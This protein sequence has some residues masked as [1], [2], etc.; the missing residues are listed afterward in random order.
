[1]RAR[2]DIADAEEWADLGAWLEREYG[3]VDGLVNNAGIPF[4]SRLHEIE[5]ADWD[6][7]L[8]VNLT[9]ALLGIQTVVR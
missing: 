6:R 1:M 2:L 8:A 7:V 3:R 5:R 9:G 4:R